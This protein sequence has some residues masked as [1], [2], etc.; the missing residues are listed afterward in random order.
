MR[1]STRFWLPLLALLAS[2]GTVSVASAEYLVEE[3]GLRFPD[4]I[5]TAKQTGGKRYPQPG[6]GHGID[7]NG[8]SYGASIYIYD[9]GASGIADGVASDVVR[10]EFAR[11]RSDIAAIQRQQNAPEPQLVG[12]RKVSAGGI[13]FLTATYRYRRGD[14]DTLSLV[15]MT[16]LRRNFIKVRIGTRASDDDAAQARLDDFLQNFGQVLA[17]A[18]SR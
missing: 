11:A 7:Y 5:G 17:G 8:G 6:L 12:E 14:L 1:V 3:A 15:A 18:N 16:G 9:R 13:E 10:S 4:Q 2:L